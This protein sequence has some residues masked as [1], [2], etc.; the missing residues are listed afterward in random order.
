MPGSL[1]APALGVAQIVGQREGGGTEVGDLRGAELVEEWVD[2]GA[3][4]G[5]DGGGGGGPDP[6]QLR[7]QRHRLARLGRQGATAGAGPTPL[8]RR[9]HRQV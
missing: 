6:G 3:R 9:S 2:V 5:E 4:G 7:Q 8:V 1:P